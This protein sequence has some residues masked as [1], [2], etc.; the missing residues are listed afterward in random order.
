M[1]NKIIIFKNDRIGDLIP[2]I[3]AINLIIDQ[4]INKKVIIY[5]SNINFNMKFLL[6]NKNVEIV[7]VKYNL[8]LTED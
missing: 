3:P 8:T 7:K 4:N 5:L 2:S 1:S 6:N